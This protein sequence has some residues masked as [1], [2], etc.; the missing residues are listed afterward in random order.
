MP[1]IK[2]LIAKLVGKQVGD[3]V[4]VSRA[5]LAAIVAVIMTAIE[6]LPP[7]FGHAPIVIPD[8]VYKFLGAAGL[9]A[10]RDAIKS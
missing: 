5:K 1:W 7:A 3:G 4:G 6:V 10:V 2:G 9:W 8:V